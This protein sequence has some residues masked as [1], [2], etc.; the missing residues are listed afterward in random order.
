MVR[1]T[2]RCWM[3]EWIQH[4]EEWVVLVPTETVGFSIFGG[5]KMRTTSQANY[6]YGGLATALWRTS[7]CIKP[8]CRT[9]TE[10]PRFFLCG[11]LK[12][13][14][15]TTPPADLDDFETRIRNEMNYRRQDRGMVR[16]AVNS[17]TTRA[18][19]CLQRNGG[20]VEN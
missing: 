14:V 10:I 11:Y 7:C 12:S 9:A 17:M 8:C 1:A 15:Y 16:R 6:C 5:F 2:W 18:E 4:Y 19:L 13:K 20:H 3:N